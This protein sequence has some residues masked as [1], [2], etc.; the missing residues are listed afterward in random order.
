MTRESDF[1]FG[2]NQSNAPLRMKRCYAD[3][4]HNGFAFPCTAGHGQR[5]SYDMCGRYLDALQK[6]FALN[7]DK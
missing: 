3:W 7:A 4:L 2:T 6:Y 1:E 5:L